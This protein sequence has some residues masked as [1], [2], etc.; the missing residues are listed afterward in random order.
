MATPAEL[1]SQAQTALERQNYPLAVDRLERF[2]AA[3]PGDLEA[4]RLLAQAWRE[5]G[6]MLAAEQALVGVLRLRGEVEGAIELWLELADL[7]L[8]MGRPEDAAR[9]CRHALIHDPS[10][11]EAYYLLG[12]CFLDARAAP[13]AVKAYREALTLNPFEREIWHNLLV[14]YETLAD[15]RGIAEAKDALAR[16]REPD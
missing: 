12:N 13:E 4:G 8:L 3:R 11:W 6:D 7:R 16:F 1:M 14:A 2:L 15:D 5:R 9:A 10:Q